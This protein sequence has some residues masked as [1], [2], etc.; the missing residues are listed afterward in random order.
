MRLS[1]RFTIGISILVAS[2]MWQGEV[3]AVNPFKA[4]KE[5]L[6]PSSDESKS[7]KNDKKSEP[8]EAEEDLSLDDNLLVPVVPE[9][10][11]DI[12][13]DYMNQLAKDLSS[14]KRETIEKW[15][16][17][18]VVVATIGTDQLFAPN[19]TVL[20]PSAK[21]F[22]MPYANLLRQMGLYKMVIV[23]HTDDTGSPEYTDA[24]SEARVNAVYDWLSRD[25][26]PTIDLIP[27]ALGA[28]DPLVE[29]NSQANRARNR[30][31]EIYIIPDR[32]VIEMAKSGKLIY[33]K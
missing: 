33:R 3:Y 5:K 16:D 26:L 29:N 31:I 4:L 11:H 1:R 10:Q 2:F 7:K 19:D 15:R 13:A 30:R 9:K 12:V 8:R 6:M 23:S 22:L 28:T 17:G 18:E 24:L 32:L 21:E 27:Y 20:R 14:R 25:Q